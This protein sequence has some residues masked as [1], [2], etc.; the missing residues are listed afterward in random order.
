M[1]LSSYCSKLLSSASGEF[2]ISVVV[3]STAE[4]QFDSFFFG[5]TMGHA[6][7]SPAWGAQS[8]NHWTSRE[9]LILF[10]N[11]YLF[12]DILY[13]MKLSSYFPLLL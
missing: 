4:F 7:S 1:I 12:I 5:C 2:L 3:L 10:Y 6:G 9:V 11:S 13:L 8:L